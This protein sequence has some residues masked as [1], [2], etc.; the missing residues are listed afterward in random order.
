MKFQSCLRSSIIFLIVFIS[1]SNGKFSP[2]IK[3]CSRNDPNIEQCIVDSVMKL[4]PLLRSGKLIEDYQVPSIEP[5]IYDDLVIDHGPGF[6]IELKDLKSWNGSNFEIVNAKVNLEKLTF[7]FTV[8]M[9]NVKMVGKY[10]MSAKL[11]L[12]ELSG[13]GEMTNLLKNSRMRIKLYAT[14]FNEDG[15]NRIKFT[16]ANVRFFKGESQIT[17]TNLFNGDPT[18]S[19]IGNQVVN[20]NQD[21]FTKEVMPALE[22]QFS[23]SFMEVAN[24]IVANSTYDE[25]LPDS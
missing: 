17:L 4:Q 2:Y 18:L 14:Q 19:M 20:D 22:A 11:P 15:K 25:I 21:I 8:T 7:D 24:K 23:K 5:F 13:N 6:R 12:L 16:K 1:S 10:K 9:P 3:I